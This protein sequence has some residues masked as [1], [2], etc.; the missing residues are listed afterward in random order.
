MSKTRTCQEKEEQTKIKAP[1]IPITAVL[2]L[3][4]AA[5]EAIY[6]NELVIESGK[7]FKQQPQITI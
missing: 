7:S 3:E 5:L 1:T 6:S 4:E 2:D